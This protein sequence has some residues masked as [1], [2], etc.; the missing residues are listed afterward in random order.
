M[1]V[2]AKRHAALAVASL[3][4]LALAGSRPRADDR[5]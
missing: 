4:I 5:L 2:R 1:K 3:L